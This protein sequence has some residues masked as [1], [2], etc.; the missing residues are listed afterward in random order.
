MFGC[1]QKLVAGRFEPLTGSS[2]S[3]AACPP[4]FHGVSCTERCHCDDQCP[5]DPQTGSCALSRLGPLKAAKTCRYSTLLSLGRVP[6]FGETDDQTV[7]TARGEKQTQ[8]F[9][10]RVSVTGHRS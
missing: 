2:V 6:V 10:D 4:G 7:E 8:A 9:S 1:T 3:L 5:C